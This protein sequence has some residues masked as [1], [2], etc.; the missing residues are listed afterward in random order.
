RRAK[1]QADQ[2]AAGFIDA[3]NG[4]AEAE[5]GPLTLG[6]LLD[7]YGEEVTPTKGK[8]TRR[9]DRVA[10]AMFLRF[11][12]RDRDPGTFSQRDWDRFIQARRTGRAGRSG[13]P[14]GN[15]TIAWDLTFLMA[16]L[17]W[18]A[19]SK[20][21]R[22]R[23]LL[24]RNPFTG[25][26]KPREKNPKR[27]VL[28]QQEYEALLEVS[29]RVGWRFHVALVLA[30]ETG[31]RI[32]AIRKLR[33]PDIDFEGRTIRWRAEHEKTGYEHRTP[34][35]DEALAALAEA[36]RMSR[37]TGDSPVLPSPRDAMRCISRVCSHNWWRKAQTL[38]GLEPKPGRGWHSLRRKFA[39]D[40][41]DLPLKVLCELGGWKSPQTVLRCYQQA[42]EGQLRKALESRRSVRA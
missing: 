31:H 36:R 14:V 27:V 13:E 26:R 22:G 5:P 25:L 2:F 11:F 32:G 21:E 37:G 15:R 34:A 10:G 7:I 8:R 9:R 19:R 17:N 41:M 42:D 35:S 12:G 4:R 20:D 28:T 29:R 6:R 40:L 33:W 38:A 1:R 24:D 39:T 3:P 18:A 16:V 23:P 30:H